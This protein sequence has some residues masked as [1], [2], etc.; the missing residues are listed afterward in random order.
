MAGPP[1]GAV[2]VQAKRGPAAWSG[3]A[4]WV[5]ALLLLAI[6]LGVTIWLIVT[7]TPIVRMI[8][9]LYQD[10]YFLR[11]SVAAWGW[12]APLVFIGI[13]AMQVIIAPIPGEITGPV[14]GALFGTTWGF[15]YSTIGLTL[16]SVAAF[17]VGRWL[18]RR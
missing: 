15:I 16:G 17:G 11:D 7:D 13:Q 12:M 1:A 9:R 10:K 8:V 6:A 4:R 14:G 18:V 5:L 2:T 3:S